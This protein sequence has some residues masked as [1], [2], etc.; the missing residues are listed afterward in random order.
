MLGGIA[1]GKA[2]ACWMIWQCNHYMV[3][4]EEYSSCNFSSLWHWAKS[5]HFPKENACTDITSQDSS[6]ICL[7]YKVAN[8]LVIWKL[9]CPISTSL[10][11]AKIAIT[12]LAR[13]G[14]ERKTRHVVAPCG[15]TGSGEMPRHSHDG[16]F[17]HM[18]GQGWQKKI[19]FNTNV[20]NMFYKYINSCFADPCLALGD[21]G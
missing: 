18:G 13:H 4:V 1:V 21:V 16:V 10:L 11:S 6:R 17:T 9:F 5:E 2:W 12:E 20:E 8:R 7:L 14:N 3:S 15:L 19:F